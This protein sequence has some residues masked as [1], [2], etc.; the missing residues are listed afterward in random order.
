MLLILIYIFPCFVINYY[1]AKLPTK[2]YGKFSNIYIQTINQNEYNFFVSYSP[3]IMYQTDLL[4]INSENNQIISQK[5]IFG[6]TLIS[7]SELSN[8]VIVYSLPNRVIIERS[9]KQN[10]I[11]FND[12]TYGIYTA[13]S[14]DSIL[15]GTINSVSL[16]VFDHYDITLYLISEPYDGITKE[17][18]IDKSVEYNNLK[19]IGLKD[20]YIYI[21]FKEYFGSGEFYIKIIDFD[22]NVIN[23]KNITYN[24]YEKIIFSELSENQK[25]NE[26]L[27]CINYE[28]AIG[29]DCQII[30]YRDSNLI[31]GETT[32]IF[33]E[34][35]A[36]APRFLINIFDGNKIGCYYSA[37]F[38]NYITIL[39]YNYNDKK[40]SF[41]KNMK[42]ISIG[43][44]Y[45][46]NIQIIT[47]I[48]QKICMF[49]CIVDINIYYFSSICLSKT[50]SLYPNKQLEFPI[51]DFIFPG[52]DEL[53]F[54]FIDIDE[55]LII[56]KN[57][58]KINERDIFTNL[59]NFS[60]YLNID[61]YLKNFY[62]VKVKIHTTNSI[63][64][65]NFDVIIDTYIK[66]YK[67]SHK[68]LKNNNYD[69]INNIIYSNL[70]ERYNIENLTDIFKLEFNMEEKPKD[71]ELIIYYNNISLNCYS[72]NTR[73]ICLAP[74]NI[75]PRT[76]KI[77]IH[78][79]LSCYN[80]IN[81]GWF[82]FIDEYVSGIYELVYYN[83][84][85]L[86]I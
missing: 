38:D 74:L 37:L 67:E 69:K 79:Y 73:I 19:L 53:K 68:C 66:T 60:Y 61:T 16:F 49:S 15:V 44:I 45:S 55:K 70:Y 41:Y 26:F 63:C 8:N 57:L 80:L 13:C 86:I 48:N 56:Y 4:R 2:S 1:I 54:S 64:Q 76:K 46:S 5:K 6:G 62:S 75:F 43:H 7:L 36:L 12:E 72:N 25:L 20:C 42:E 83:F 85:I 77:Y 71:N 52:L 11:V 65:I 84:E 9:W 78:S 59:D 82:E 32:R 34:R 23:T 3:I 51:K 21:L 40:L 39:E 30:E 22:L 33:S 81:I 29:T 31:F 58:V 27:I 18:I 50:L 28:R 24:N 35:S 47:M 17:T 10:E 14:S